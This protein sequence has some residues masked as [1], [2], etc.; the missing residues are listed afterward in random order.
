MKPID[1]AIF[2]PINSWAQAGLNKAENWINSW[3]PV[4]IGKACWTSLGLF[5]AARLAGSLEA[6]GLKPAAA[7]AVSAAG[8]ASTLN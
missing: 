6:A 2:K 7:S 5:G 3:S 8:I 1:N 4:N